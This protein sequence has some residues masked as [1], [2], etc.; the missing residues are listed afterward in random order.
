MRK[1]EDIYGRKWTLYSRL[2]SVIMRRN[3][4]IAGNHSQKESSRHFVVAVVIE[5]R[6]HQKIT[7]SWI[8]RR[9]GSGGGGGADSATDPGSNSRYKRPEQWHPFFYNRRPK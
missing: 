6:I 3:K 5:I 8:A 4:R 7:K 2:K 9:V 1:K